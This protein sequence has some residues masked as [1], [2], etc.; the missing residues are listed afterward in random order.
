GQWRRRGAD[1]QL[2]SA[3]E[4]ARLTG[5][6]RYSGGWIDR[7]GGTLQPLSYVRGLA[8]AARGPGARIFGQ[9]P[10]TYPEQA[11]SD[12][13]VRTPG[14]SVSSA[15]VILATAAYADRL[16]DP[17]RRTMIPVPSFQ[18]AT[19]PIPEKL[20]QSILPGGQAASDTWHLLRYFR[21]DPTGRLIMGS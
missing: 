17:V 19:E 4:T 13:G 2:L 11:G 20:R 9:R 5:S 16:V 12:W 14:R 8:P 21:L 18:V 3:A 7:R 15:T 10:A 1:V 6:Q